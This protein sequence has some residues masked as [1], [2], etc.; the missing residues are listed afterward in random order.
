MIPS[1]TGGE[2]LNGSGQMSGGAGRQILYHDE[3]YR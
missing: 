2:R 1:K 3:E